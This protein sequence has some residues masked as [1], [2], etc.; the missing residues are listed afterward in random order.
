[1]HA[2]VGALVANGL[3]AVSAIFAGVADVVDLILR[4]L[5]PELGSGTYRLHTAAVA[6]LPLALGD[7]LSDSDHD[8]RAFVACEAIGLGE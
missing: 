8:A 2:S 6:Q 5:E 7:I 4:K 3:V 1:M